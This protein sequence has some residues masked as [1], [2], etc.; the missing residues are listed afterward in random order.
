MIYL[1]KVIFLNFV[2]EFG[3]G[4]AGLSDVSKSTEEVWYVKKNGTLYP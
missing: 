2:R 1:D 4:P 3:Y